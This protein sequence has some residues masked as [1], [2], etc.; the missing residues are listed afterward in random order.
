MN[1]FA[2]L[3][4]RNVFRVGIAYGVTAWLLAQVAGLAADT[5]GA[6]DWVMQMFVTFLL[7][8][9]P[10]VLVF[11]WA[12]EL[13]PEGLRREK[14]LGPGESTADATAGKLD[15]TIM[16]VLVLALAY[17]A[18]DKFLLDPRRDAEMLEA[19]QVAKGPETDTETIGQGKLP[20]DGSHS[21]ESIAVLPFVNMSEDPGNEYFAEG[22]S[23]ELLNLLVRIPDLKVAARTSSFSYKGKDV[24]VGQIGEELGVSNVL[25][26]S[27]R[28]SGNQVRITAQ[29]IQADDGFHLWSETYDRTLDD[30]FA[31]QDEIAGAV[32]TALEMRL[33]NERAPVRVTA[34]EVYQLYLEGQYFL[35]LDTA[36]SRRTAVEKL[37]QA[38]AL[39]PD[40][41]PAWTDLGIT[42]IRQSN[43]DNIEFDAGFKLAREALQKA[44]ALDES[45]AIAWA[46]MGY[47]QAYYDW[48]LDSA[49]ESHRKAIALE[50]GNIYVINAAALLPAMQGQT[51]RSLELR[52][53]VIELDPINSVPLLQMSFSL[54]VVGQFDEAERTIHRLQVLKPGHPAVAD[55]LARISLLRG[56]AGRALELLSD[57]DAGSVAT[58]FRAM[59]LHDLGQREKAAADIA[60]TIAEKERDTPYYLAHYH[61]WTGNADAAFEA[62]DLSIQAGNR[63]LIYTLGNPFLLKLRDDPRWPGL[64]ARI[65]LLEAWRQMP[66]KHGGPKA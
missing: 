58:V 8:G 36:E 66:P 42:V 49:T 56:D 5:F 45:N 17:F 7:L 24:Q 44:I 20:E 9:F 29:L 65:G 14:D 37:N 3:K 15:R 6:P 47:I 51:E 18:F 26:G 28:K 64:L 2:E 53:K 38:L 41:A 13:T 33:M 61:A 4:R 34:P 31:V 60:L 25:E 59:A 10:L 40:Y 55:M 30:I 63:Q 23:E 52:R 11:A 1:L 62:L 32:V 39:D 50:P 35:G 48:D 16:V 21:E 43:F 46:S 19:V 57:P 22:L 27:V 54:M 12:Y